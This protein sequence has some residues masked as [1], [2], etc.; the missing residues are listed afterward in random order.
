[1][2]NY[3]ENISTLNTNNVSKNSEKELSNINN[4]SVEEVLDID[5]IIEKM[6]DYKNKSIFSK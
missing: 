5:D 6:R 2:S 1:M 4:L 3:E